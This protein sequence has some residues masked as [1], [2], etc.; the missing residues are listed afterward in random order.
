MNFILIELEFG[1]I[2]VSTY[3][4]IKSKKNKLKKLRK[5]QS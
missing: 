2:I 5:K 1:K 3:N 4:Y